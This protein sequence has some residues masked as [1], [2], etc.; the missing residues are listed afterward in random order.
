MDTDLFEHLGKIKDF[1]EINLRSTNK[2][3][4]KVLSYITCIRTVFI[5][6]F[7]YWGK[8]EKSKFENFPDFLYSYI[9]TL[10]Y[11][12]MWGTPRKQGTSNILGKMSFWYHC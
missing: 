11:D 1:E 8:I 4:V 10:V 6:T 2:S 3:T 7:I 9:V 12:I 5:S